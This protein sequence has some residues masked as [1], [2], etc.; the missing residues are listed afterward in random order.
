MPALGLGSITSISDLTNL[1]KTYYDRMLLET[2]DP[3]VKFFQFGIKKPLPRG[4]GN[5][6]TW[7]RPRRLGIGQKLTP[8]IKPS[9]N[10]LSTVRVSALIEVYG[11]YTLIEDLV[12]ATAIVDPLEIA[13]QE[14]AKQ[15]AETIDRATMQA[16]LF[17]DDPLT[18]TSAVH[19][20]KASA[21]LYISTNT[22]VANVYSN[23]LI[24]VSD[25]RA[26]TTELR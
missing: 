24:A 11:G 9:A 2:L 10:E 16:L 13:T 19:L 5:A 20:V 17:Y 8:G 14:L 12:S 25:V 18:A 6:I 4:E 23:T 26:A 7:N 21:G 15:A 1:V 3:E 22:F